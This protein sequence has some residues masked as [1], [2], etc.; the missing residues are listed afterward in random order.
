VG[1]GSHFGPPR[2][3]IRVARL[4]SSTTRAVAWRAGPM[5]QPGLRHRRARLQL[6]AGAVRSAHA[7]SS[8][9]DPNQHLEFGGQLAD[10][11]PASI[12][13]G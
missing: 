6:H 12:K 5:G 7:P 4:A 1:R 3:L 9:L 2:P 11:C 8:S 13:G 10:W